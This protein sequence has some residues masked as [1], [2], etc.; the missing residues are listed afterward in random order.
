M[1]SQQ[2]LAA[3]ALAAPLVYSSPLDLSKRG[4][5]TFHVDQVPK[6]MK[7]TKN[8]A[9]AYM[10]ALGKYKATIPSHVSQAAAV[11]SGSATATPQGD[12]LEY[13]GKC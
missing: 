13:T 1:H 4:Q 3:L 5:G 6:S 7:S 2:I 10:K 11:Q 8:A 12:D 9:S